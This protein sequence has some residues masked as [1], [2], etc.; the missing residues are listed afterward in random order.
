MGKLK[1]NL[2]ITRKYDGLN[3]PMKIKVANCLLLLK[4]YRLL[5]MIYALKEK[6]RISKYN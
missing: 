4:M 5:I 6:R 3:A 2:Y 1:M